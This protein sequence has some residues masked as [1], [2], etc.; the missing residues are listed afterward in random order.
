M[1][2]VQ[3]TRSAALIVAPERAPSSRWLLDELPMASGER[4]P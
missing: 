4:K 1:S 2:A 3:D